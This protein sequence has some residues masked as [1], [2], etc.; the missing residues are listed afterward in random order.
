M[1]YYHSLKSKAKHRGRVFDITY[2]DWCR[3]CEE[4]GYMELKGQGSD[5]MTI[6][7]HEASLG[8][9]YNNMRMISQHDNVCKGQLEK[10]LMR[11]KNDEWY[12]AFMTEIETDKAEKDRQHNTNDPPF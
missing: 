4:T 6:D 8:Y 10:S 7:C 12:A 2:V 3:W 9:T 11:I 5:D 1:A